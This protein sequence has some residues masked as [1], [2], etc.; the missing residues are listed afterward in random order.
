MAR[1]RAGTSVAAGRT[2]RWRQLTLLALAAFPLLALVLGADPIPQDPRYH[3]LADTRTL[4]GVPSFANVA[5]NLAFLIVGALGLHLCLTRG[6]NGA[7]RSWLVFFAGAS[8]IAFGSAYYHW[9][10]DDA[11]L[12]WD[13]LPMTIVFMALLCALVSEHVRLDLER[14]LLPLTLAIGVASIAWWRYSGDLRIYAWVQFAPLAMIVFL[15][16]AY[17]GRYTHREYLG[18]GLAVY[19]LAKGAEAA[20]GA[21]FELTGGTLSGHTVKH[22]LAAIALFAVYLMLGKRRPIV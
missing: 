19:V 1:K 14:A 16:I 13:R 2:L 12:T 6:V 22:L 10:P 20:D 17:R 5:S 7:A 3:A 8:A 4:L 21:I 18:Y 15:L 11:A 9:T